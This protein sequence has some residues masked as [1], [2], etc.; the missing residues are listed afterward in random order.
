M[1]NYGTRISAGSSGTKTLI[2]QNYVS[3]DRHQWAI[4][5]WRNAWQA[6]ERAG[7]DPKKHK[8]MYD[9][10]KFDFDG[11]D[12]A[13]KRRVWNDAEPM[14][15]ADLYK[16]FSQ[17][18]VS[19]GASK[20]S[21]KNRRGQYGQGSRSSILPHSGL[22]VATTQPKGDTHVLAIFD[23]GDD[24]A[25]VEFSSLGEGD[26]VIRD[27]MAVLGTGQW[28][29]INDDVIL[30]MGTELIDPHVLKHGGVTFI[31]LGQEILDDYIEGDPMKEE[32]G[33]ALVDD[34]T[35][36]IWNDLPVTVQYMHNPSEDKRPHGYTVETISRGIQKVDPRKIHSYD[37][38]IA[39]V[40][41]GMQG[42]IVID[43][44][45]TE[46]DV[47]LLPENWNWTGPHSLRSVNRRKKK[48]GAVEREPG[49]WYFKVPL[50]DSWFPYDGKGFVMIRYDNEMMPLGKSSTRVFRVSALNK[51]GIN[52]DSVAARTALV[53]RPPALDESDPKAPWGVTQNLA[54]SALE[55]PNGSSLPIDEWRTSF[56]DQVD[57]LDFL[58]KA[59]LEATPKREH[60]IDIDALKRLKDSIRSRLKLNRLPL[61]IES[62]TPTDETG[63]ITDELVTDVRNPGK[64]KGTGKR[65]KRSQRTTTNERSIVNSNPGSTP[66]INHQWDT[67]PEVD[68][69][70]P[71]EW[72]NK[73]VNHTQYQSNIYCVVERGVLGTTLYMNEGYSVFIN[74]HLYYSGPW[75]AAPG[76][77]RAGVLRRTHLDVIPVIIRNAYTELALSLVLNAMDMSKKSTD[78]ISMARF[79][80]LTSPEMMTMALGGFINVD[81]AI[82]D[83]IIR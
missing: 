22:M 39:R 49:K 73:G 18:S 81:R 20:W 11:S 48:D 36:R 28:L 72:N 64:G 29:E 69:L 78:S 12:I 75:F 30:E 46:A 51:W 8:L 2:C 10:V 66:V 56:F 76:K 21:M 16:Y 58:V 63:E 47:Y 9:Y 25:L 41:P 43:N 27:E 32:S 74:Q 57:Q 35:N 33:R 19:G 50:K 53:I 5:L 52:I 17:I 55:G 15:P 4:E 71:V 6:I 24:F 44:D 3:G 59:L 68:W 60:H 79:D 42:T 83:A 77:N 38:W 26:V 45:G 62:D 13:W 1:T 61:R 31:L 70:T 23:T 65:G 7:G 37:E 14:T 54:R 34:I 40:E 67:L 82:E 80:E